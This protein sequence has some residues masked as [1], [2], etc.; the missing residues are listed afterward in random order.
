LVGR[1]FVNK[2]YHENCTSGQGKAVIDVSFVI[3]AVLYY[4]DEVL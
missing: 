3:K 1:A 4:K 2:A